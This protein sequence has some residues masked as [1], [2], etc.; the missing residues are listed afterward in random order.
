V[1]R[2]FSAGEMGIRDDHAGAGDKKPGAGLVQSFQIDHGWL[3][4]EH[5]FF[6]RQLGRHGDA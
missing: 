2:F 3:G 1:Q 6:E 5:E 4:L